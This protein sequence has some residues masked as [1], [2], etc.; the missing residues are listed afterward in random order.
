MNKIKALFC[1]IVPIALAFLFNTKLG[2]TP[3]L[4]KFLNPFM[5]FWQNAENNH[6]MFNHK[7]KIKGAIDQIEIVFDD[8]MIPHI[9]A[10][11]D[12][13]LYLATRI[14]YRY[15]PPLANGFPNPFCRRK[16]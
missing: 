8:R 2:S 16:N 10:Q 11:N 7:A 5:G 6:F 12:H 13:D 15:A 14:C 9:F 1:V 4:L 3:P